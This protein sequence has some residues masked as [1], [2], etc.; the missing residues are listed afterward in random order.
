MTAAFQK[1]QDYVRG[2]HPDMEVFL[3]NELF[4]SQG[5]LDFVADGRCHTLNGTRYLLVDFSSNESRFQIEAALSRILNG[6]WIPVL[7]HVERYREL[8][9][10]DAVE[11]L[12]TNGV[13][14]QMDA[15]ALFGAWGLATRHYCRRLLRRGLID[16]VA[17]DAHGTENGQFGLCRARKYVEA[18]FGANEGEMLFY[19]LPRRI[20]H[21][22][23][24]RKD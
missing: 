10:L 3:G 13:L 8:R 5:A 17:S 15:S 2:H 12:R 22:E 18:H 23:E 16:I 9:C 24:I 4:Y 11:H 1:L 19:T 20:L 21:G 6:G 7:A 14:M